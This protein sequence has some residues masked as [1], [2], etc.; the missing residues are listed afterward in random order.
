MTVVDTSIV[1]ERVKLRNPI[2]EDITAI[3]LIEYPKII[4]YKHFHGEVIFPIKQDFIL[5]HKLQL[6][7]LKTGKPQAFS[8]LLVAAIVINRDED[9]V[10]QDQDF[11]HI[12]NAAKKLGHHMKLKIL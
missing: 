12:S 9:L 11:Q 5:A 7:L 2:S 1:I 8:D 10:T 3:T 4:Y 6:E